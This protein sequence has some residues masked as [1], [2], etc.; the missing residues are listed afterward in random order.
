MQVRN[1][2]AFSVAFWGLLGSIEL[3]QC[4]RPAEEEGTM[5]IMRVEAI[6][7][8]IPYT[9]LR[10]NMHT[11][12][13]GDAITHLN[14]NVLKVH[15]NEGV[16]GLG[17]AT[18]DGVVDEV[19]KSV[20]PAVSGLNPLDFEGTLATPEADAGWTRLCAGLD[21]AL[22]DIAGKVRGVPM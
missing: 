10:R 1:G 12:V 5:K 14:T 9:I 11:E 18:G 17:E 16:A 2:L 7:V 15:T 8:S 21:F 22:H 3:R 4:G 13:R 19:A 20:N 6:P